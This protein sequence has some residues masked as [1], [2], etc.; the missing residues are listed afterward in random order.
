RYPTPCGAVGRPRRQDLARPAGG[1]MT[2]SPIAR[3]VLDMALRNNGYHIS[4]EAPEGLQAEW[5]WAD[6][7]FAPGRCFVAY[8]PGGR[9]RAIVA[10]SLPHVAR[11]FTEEGYTEASDV[12]LPPGAAAAF[13]VPT[14][15]LPKVVRRI[16]ELSRSLPTAPLDRFTEELQI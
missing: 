5:L 11:A 7:T 2:L 3:N 9:D 16:F 8:A 14:V 12:P 13:L 1:A 4:V 6:A 15:A 10:T